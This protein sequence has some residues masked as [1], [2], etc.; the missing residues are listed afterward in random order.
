MRET[1]I[2]RQILDKVQGLA[3]QHRASRVKRIRIS[4]GPLSGIDTDNLLAEFPLLRRGTL[5]EHAELVI[6]NSPIRVYCQA[7]GEISQ[8]TPARIRCRVCDSE[9]IDVLSGDDMRIKGVDFVTAR[10]SR[11]VEKAIPAS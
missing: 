6:Q 4:V 10:K 7:C 2:C 3:I 5:A 11:S 9:R 8:I 1:V